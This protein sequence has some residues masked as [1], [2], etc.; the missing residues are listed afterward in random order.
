MTFQADTQNFCK[1]FSPLEGALTLIYILISAATC[2]FGAAAIDKYDYF[3]F[4]KV[5]ALFMVYKLNAA[6]L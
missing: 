6:F 5:S 3:G 1:R 4:Y 2:L